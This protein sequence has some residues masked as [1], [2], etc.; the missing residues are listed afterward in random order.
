MT[1]LLTSPVGLAARTVAR[2]LGVTSVIVRLLN[3]GGYEAKFH[4]AMMAA[5][6][7][8]MTLWDVG[9]NVGYYTRQFA[10]AVGPNGSVHAF[11]PGPRN[12]IALDREVAGIANVRVVPVALGAGNGEVRFEECDPETDRI[13]SAAHVVASGGIAV[14]MR[15]ADAMIADGDVPR[16]DFVKIDVEGYELDVLR[17][18]SDALADRRLVTL[19]IE[20]H[21]TLL[22]ARGMPS[23]PKTIETMLE[24]AGFAVAWPDASH[25][26]ATR[27]AAEPNWP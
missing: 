27:K 13:G 12:R 15:T 23:A 26:L 22:A 1:S 9:A 21:F 6:R 10:D 18:M 17:G 20:V 8:G 11:E 16:P 2:R 7:P 4:A 5:I 14:S 19:A 3:R 25:I 24:S